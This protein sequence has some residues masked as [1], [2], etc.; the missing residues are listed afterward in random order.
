MVKKKSS[1]TP[2]LRVRT[3]MGRHA[4]QRAVVRHDAGRRRGKASR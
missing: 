3:E 2:A 4:L 1:T